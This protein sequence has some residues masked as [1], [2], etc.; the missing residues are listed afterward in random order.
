MVAQEGRPGLLCN[1]AIRSHRSQC[2]TSRI[3]PDIAGER[4][5]FHTRNGNRTICL[6]KEADFNRFIGNQAVRIGLGSTRRLRPTAVVML[7]QEMPFRP[8]V[9]TRTRIVQDLVVCRQDIGRITC[10]ADRQVGTCRQRIAFVGLGIL[11]VAGI[12]FLVADSRFIRLDE[13]QELRLVSL[14]SRLGCRL[15][16]ICPVVADILLRLVAVGC[17][18]DCHIFGLV[19]ITGLH[20]VI[21]LIQVQGRG[22][23]PGIGRTGI[24]LGVGD[25]NDTVDVVVLDPTHL[26][27]C[28]RLVLDTD[29]R[30]TVH[31]INLALARGQDTA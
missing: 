5:V 8:A 20:P 10:L 31:R 2:R 27:G 14:V 17:A 19:R 3:V 25:F 12:L 6:A 16:S 26:K 23:V 7:V 4:Q 13:R 18:T 15:G 11:D 29:V 28:I 9:H 21:V 30:P 22:T 1:R 24:L